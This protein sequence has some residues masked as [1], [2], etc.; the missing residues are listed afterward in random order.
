MEDGGRNVERESV[1]GYVE[2]D[3]KT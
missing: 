2:E 1:G 3:G